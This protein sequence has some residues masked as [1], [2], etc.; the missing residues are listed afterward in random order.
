MWLDNMLTLGIETSC[1]ETGV[2]ITEG[3]K[4]LSN[5]VSSSV[6][7]HKKYGGVVPEIASRFH[8]EFILE[9][10]GQA[11]KKARKDLD[12]IDL[13]AV[14]NGPGL[15][16]A[17]L[18]G[19]SLG[20]SL[21][22]SLKVPLIGVNHVLAHLYSAFLNEGSMPDLPFI[23]LVVSGGH[24][25]LFLCTD[26]YRQK[27]LGQ[28]RDDAVGEAFDKVAKIL[29]LAYPGGP[30]IEKRAALSKNRGRVKLPGTYLGKDSLDFS[31]SGVKTAV[32]YYVRGKQGGCAGIGGRDRQRTNDEINDICYAFQEN[33]LGVLV[34]KAFLAARIHGV[35]NIVAGGGVAANSRLRKKFAEASIFSGGVKVYFPERAYCMDNAAMVGVLG[36][37]LYKRGRR[38]DL[39][40]N[41]EPNLEVV[42]A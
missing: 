28:T 10:L 31:F 6:R 24:T 19:I 20:K 21:S 18:T 2:A 26:N 15:V 40:L 17:L 42:D 30:V 37:E 8:V 22:Y 7:L 16:G 5:I 3:K 4:V 23:G 38:S 35:K 25:A 1:D 29:K 32:L 11:L 33:A 36:E 41:A 34:E 27:L 13:I 14:T 9:T 12:D 39:Y